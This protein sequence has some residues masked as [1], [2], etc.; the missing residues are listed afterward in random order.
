MFLLL[1][2]YVL[3]LAIVFHSAKNATKDL[4]KRSLRT[5]VQY[6]TKVSM[7]LPASLEVYVLISA[8]S[9]AEN[10]LISQWNS[11]LMLFGVRLYC[12][13]QNY[14]EANRE[15]RYLNLC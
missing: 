5:Q 11:R 13:Q 12:S 6:K 10:V 9:K 4:L 14:H 3:I 1:N 15:S 2:V 8:I 7:F